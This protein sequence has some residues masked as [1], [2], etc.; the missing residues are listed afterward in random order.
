M[1]T[2][3]ALISIIQSVMFAIGII[4]VF[5][6]PWLLPGSFLSD[7]TPTVVTELRGLSGYSVP[8][9]H[10]NEFRQSESWQWWI[11][12]RRYQEYVTAISRCYVRT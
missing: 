2:A 9:L 11:E 3:L 1:R 8:C 4:A 6:H 12:W 7:A 5:Q 10:V